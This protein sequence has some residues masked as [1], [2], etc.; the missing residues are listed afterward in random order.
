MRQQGPQLTNNKLLLGIEAIMNYTD[1]IFSGAV[2][3][4]DT[5]EA[6]R[7]RLTKRSKGPAYEFYSNVSQSFSVR[8]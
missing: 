6:K 1:N 5:G 4:R 7:G 2:F 3:Q 8:R